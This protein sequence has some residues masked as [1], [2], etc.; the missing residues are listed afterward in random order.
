MPRTKSASALIKEY[1]AANG[2]TQ[3]DFGEIAK[4][5]Q[6]MVSQWLS[7]ARP[8]SAIAAFN[9]EQR[10]NGAIKK[11]EIRSDLFQNESNAA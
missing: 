11:H 3:K 6:G 4:V 1:M 10:T 2:L 8:V 7:G 9:I 5:P